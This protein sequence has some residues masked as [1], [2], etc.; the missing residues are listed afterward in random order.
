MDHWS[1]S[2]LLRTRTSLVIQ[3]RLIVAA[4]YG[5]QFIARNWRPIISS[6]DGR[7]I[8]SDEQPGERSSKT[9]WLQDK[10]H[11]IANAADESNKWVSSKTTQA[12]HASQKKQFTR[13]P[14]HKRSTYHYNR[15]P[16]FNNE[17]HTSLNERQ[18]LTKLI[19][20]FQQ[21]NQI[22]LP[23]RSVSLNQH[24]TERMDSLH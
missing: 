4:G 19:Q 10:N 18:S 11:G 16:W 3:E 14:R 2:R 5:P 21:K 6:S 9:P 13:L 12:I 15:K 8:P 24:S 17:L 23:L 1:L 7:F 22:G 20:L